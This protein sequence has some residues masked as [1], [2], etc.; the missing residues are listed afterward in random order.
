LEFK[1]IEA[2]PAS[3]PSIVSLSA[4]KKEGVRKLAKLVESK[5][6]EMGISKPTW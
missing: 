1:L 2:L 6:S 3:K 4:I 5:L